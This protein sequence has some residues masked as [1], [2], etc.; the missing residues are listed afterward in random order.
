MNPVPEPLK[1][2]HRPRFRTVLIVLIVVV[3]AKLLE[4]ATV[5]EQVPDSRDDDVLGGYQRATSTT[6]KI[7]PSLQDHQ[8]RLFVLARNQHGGHQHRSQIYI[9]TTSMRLPLPAS[10]FVLPRTGPNPGRQVVSTGMENC[11][12]QTVSHYHNLDVFVVTYSCV[13]ANGCWPKPQNYK[14]SSKLRQL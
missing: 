3:R 2:F 4:Y 14:A 12:A 6:A 9:A 11:C 13:L 8:K 5:G 10:R 7:Q 1:L